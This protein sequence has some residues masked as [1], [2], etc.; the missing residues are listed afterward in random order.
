[1]RHDRACG[2]GSVVASNELRRLE[3][4]AVLGPVTAL[5]TERL[6]LHP[7]DAAEAER[8][9]ARQPGPEDSWAPDFPLGGDVIGLTAFLRAMAAEGDQ[10]PFARYRITRTADGRAVGGIGFK[11]QPDNGSVEIGYGLV[12]SARGNGYAP[13]AAQ[14][15][16]A[17]ARQQ[18]LSLIVADTEADN[19]ASQRT[20]ERAGFTQ[21]G[22]NGNLYL[23]AFVLVP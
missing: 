8:I 9:V 16:V 14:A 6:I 21:T 19:I 2:W 10:R 1:M 17:L 3:P 5:H 11:G 7:I 13:E 20:L 22:T 4:P 12:P 23:Y 15:L 18:G